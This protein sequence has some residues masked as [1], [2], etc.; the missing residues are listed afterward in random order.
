MLSNRV[1][2]LVAT[3][4]LVACADPTGFASDENVTV[5][6]TDHGLVARNRSSYTVFYTA[7][8][9][10]SL[11][12]WAPCTQGPDACPHIDAGATGTIAFDMILGWQNDA[13][14][15]DVVFNYYRLTRDND[16]YRAEDIRRITISR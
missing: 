13:D 6:L 1:A 10:R 14:A 2:V 15:A 4:T 3:I 9:P 11:L 12:T 5:E 8:N 7:V 16:T